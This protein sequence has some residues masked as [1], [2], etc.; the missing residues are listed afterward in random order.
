V[1]ALDRTREELA[2]LKFWLAIAAATD[3]SVAGWAIS[4]ATGAAPLSL[5]FVLAAP[6]VVSLSS[7]AMAIHRQIAQRIH[8]IGQ[9]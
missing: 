5:S 2:Y 4:T 1:A 3:I 6:G 9:L 7:I 8:K